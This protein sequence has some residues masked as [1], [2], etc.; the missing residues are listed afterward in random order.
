MDD[1]I[2][3]GGGPTGF[4]NALGLA[5]AGVKVRLL[6][7][8]PGIQDSPRAMVYHWSVLDGIEKLGI[9]DDAYRIGFKKQDYCY[10]VHKTQEKIFFSLNV[11]EGHVRHPN[12]LHMGQNKLAEIAMAR[13]SNHANAKVEFD[14]K[15]T[16]LTQDAEGV[17]VRA[18]APGGPVEHRAK[19]VIGADG[20]ASTVRELL[21]LP[22][23]GM[24]WPERFVATNLYYDFE[25]FGYARSMMV[26]DD[27][28]GAIIAKIDNDGLWRCTYMEDASLPEETFMERLPEAYSRL[29]PGNESY[30]VKLASPYRMHQRSAPTFRKGRVVLA[31]DAAHATN[32]TGGLGLTSGLFDTFALYP[33]LAA[34]IMNGATDDALDRWSA[35]RKDKFD[36]I[37]SPQ[38]VK[39]KRMIYHAN[40]GGQALEEALIGM[41]Q[42]TDHPDVARERAMFTKTLETAPPL[43]ETV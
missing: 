31:G 25:K 19:Y 23:E 15:V 21:E 14:T 18:E 41:R 11:L 35:E 36:N 16:G 29:L 20:A 26:I 22:F 3:V 43:P 5:R 13:L 38:A 6:E 12:N 10:L 37:A 40:G 27:R 34:I 32:P 30:E 17:T 7:R 24:T 39:N 9:L 33:T 8:A 2:I 4:L 1:V 42:L 28:D